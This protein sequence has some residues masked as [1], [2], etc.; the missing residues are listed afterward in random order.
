MQ[1]TQQTDYALRMLIYLSKTP[2]QGWVGVREIS[3]AYQI[4]HN[5]MLKVTQ[6]LV[7]LGFLESKRG[8]MGGVRLGHKPQQIRI[9]EVVRRVE[10]TLGLAECMRGEDS[11]PLLPACTLRS[12]YQEALDAFLSVLDRYT[13]ADCADEPQML[14]HV[15]AL[16]AAS[17]AQR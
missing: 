12:V 15:L 1:L 2:D 10:N 8:A 4:S 16:L 6:S 5:H 17:R 7:A 3:D 13:I 11:C 14:S 9:G